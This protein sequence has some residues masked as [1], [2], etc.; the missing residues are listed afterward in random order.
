MR[1]AVAQI[2]PAHTDDQKELWRTME[3]RIA[4]LGNTVGANASCVR[5]LTNSSGVK[6]Y[7]HQVYLS[8]GGS[9]SVC[10]W[11]YQER[12]HVR[13]SLEQA[14]SL[15]AHKCDLC[16]KRPSSAGSAEER[17]VSSDT[18]IQ[19]SHRSAPIP[20]LHSR[21]QCFTRLASTMRCSSGFMSVA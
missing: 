13:V 4:A 19:P 14:L 11:R 16:G 20:L 15:L 2:L 21:H 18:G 8:G 5:N 10:R 9:L 6:G 3:V 12:P 17:C 7:R 1:A